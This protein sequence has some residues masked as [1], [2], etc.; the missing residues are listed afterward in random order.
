M[1]NVDEEPRIATR[2]DF[3][4]IL[5]SLSAFWGERDMTHLHHPTAVEEFGDSALVI[6]DSAG[7]VAAYL[8][9]MILSA[10]RLG[11]VHVVAVR[12]DQR[13]HG[14]GR[15]LYRAFAD[16]A[17]A[18]GCSRIKAITT[19][20]NTESIA[21]HQSIG[22]DAREIPDYSGP[23]RPRIVL[24]RDLDSPTRTP[25][26]PIAGVVL[27]A[28]TIDDIDNVLDFWRLAAEDTDR[29]ADRR[30]ALAELIARDAQA[31]VIATQHESIIGSVVIGWDGWRAHLYRLAVHPDHRR[32]GMAGWLLAVAEQR[33]QRAG[34]IRID[35]MVL[36]S[37]ASAHTLWSAA[38]YIRQ[39]NWSRWIKPVPR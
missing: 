34:A 26:P 9:G 20:D 32:R 27:R 30:P 13:G 22:M 16:L 38:G 18:D 29:P 3:A 6:H 39:Q 10:R 35:A 21:F 33:L 36:N 12:D 17:A 37:N 28:A 15:S 7:R 31:L 14:H 11:Y 25:D 5:G 8:F 19:P 1:S 23:G 24:S 4:E 2:R